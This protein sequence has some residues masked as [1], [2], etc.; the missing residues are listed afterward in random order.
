M[1]LVTFEIFTNLGPT[2]RI[3]ALV[4]ERII[5][6]NLGYAQYLE[7]KLSRY[8]T[9]EIADVLLPPDMIGF[10][11]SG[12]E[13]KNAAQTTIDYINDLQSK[14]SSL[15]F[16]NKKI[17]YELA[18]VELKA[19][20]PRPNSIR[21]FMGFDEHITRSG[22][23]EVSPVYYKIPVCYKGNPD[24]V[25]GPGETVDWPSFCDKLDFELE[26]GV[27]IGK[28]GR[29]IPR[30]KAG[31]H[32]GGFTIFND[33]SAR[34]MQF[35]EMKVRL[36]PAKGK[37]FC[38]AMGPC[39]VTPDEVDP[40]NMRTV[41]RIND[42]IL[43][44]NNTKTRYWTWGH[45]IEFASMEETLYP[46]DF[47]GSGTVGRGCGIELGQLLNPGDIVELEIEGIGVLK[48]TIGE[49]PSFKRIF[50]R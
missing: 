37:D 20:V 36:G 14:N 41:V 45:I 12:E 33:F 22:T 27:Y 35:E 44:E 49:K 3:G 32:I 24:A 13:G 38:N 10:L 6:L 11:C 48:N 28:K 18:D 43:S 7:E 9:C 26:C 30:E 1:R 47:L 2:Q 16:V 17:V 39:M 31:E 25:I 5:D 23:R 42:K 46:G 34:D 15:N 19:P 4:K 21:D 40:D 50:T 8:R 29:N